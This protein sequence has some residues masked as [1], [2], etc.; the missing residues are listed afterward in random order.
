[1]EALANLVV[2]T[3]DL[4]EAEGRALGRHLLRLEV[5][6][7]LIVAAALIGILGLG[8]FVF[9]LFLLLAQQVSTPI[10]ATLCGVSGLVI[11]GALGWAAR[12]IIWRK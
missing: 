3:A 7:I 8:F 12:Q 9:G 5:A 11:A 4:A 10:A 6:A 2:A 1:M